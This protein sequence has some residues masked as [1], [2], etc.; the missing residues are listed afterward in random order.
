MRRAP[1]FYFI[2]FND[3]I[4]ERLQEEEQQ[5]HE[6]WERQQ[7]PKLPKNSAGSSFSVAS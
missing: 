7:E 2:F 5:Q 4:F 6:K 3:S 1:A